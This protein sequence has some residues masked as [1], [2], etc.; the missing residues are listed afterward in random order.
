MYVL[1]HHFKIFF[2]VHRDGDSSFLSSFLLGF[3]FCVVVVD[4]E[5]ASDLLLPVAGETGFLDKVSVDFVL[6]H[7]V[8]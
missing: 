7:C 2:L 4:D 3:P 5:M 6:N 1:F 8:D